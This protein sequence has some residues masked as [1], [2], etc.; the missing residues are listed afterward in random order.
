MTEKINTK[1]LKQISTDGN[2][3]TSDVLLPT[4]NAVK[5]Y[6]DTTAS[7]LQSEINDL[8]GRGRF[9]SIWNCATGLAETNP[10]ESPYPYK[11]GDYFIVGTV[12]TATP[13]VNYKPNG[14]SYTTGVAS[15]TMMEQLGN[16]KQIANVN[17][18]SL[19]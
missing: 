9:L 19:V 17:I 10:P 16:C 11:A 8:S 18:L 3:G 2:L 14:S 6:V 4:Q 12:S 5:T 15:T 13:A 7:G 1:Q